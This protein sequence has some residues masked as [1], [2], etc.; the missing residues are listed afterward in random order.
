MMTKNLIC[1]AI[2]CRWDISLPEVEEGSWDV[3]QCSRCLQK[4]MPPW[5]PPFNEGLFPVLWWKFKL[6]ACGFFLGHDWQSAEIGDTGDWDSSCD[7]CGINENAPGFLDDEGYEG[8]NF[9]VCSWA[10]FRERFEL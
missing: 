9:F 3:S 1:K 6:W 8:Q 10:K 4:G 7:R 5:Y 2:G